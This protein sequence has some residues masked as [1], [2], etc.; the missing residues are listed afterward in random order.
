MKTKISDKSRIRRLMKEC[1]VLRQ[2]IFDA[3]WH[4]PT[5]NSSGACPWCRNQEHWKHNLNCPVV[6]LGLVRDEDE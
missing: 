3:Q 1:R 5:S 2:L 4:Q 6:T